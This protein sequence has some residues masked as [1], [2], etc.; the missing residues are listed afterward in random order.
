[1]ISKKWVTSE[2]VAKAP[3][4]LKTLLKITPKGVYLALGERLINHFLRPELRAGEL[5]FI[6][7]KGVRID[8]T[9]IEL[10]FVVHLR[11]GTLRLAPDSPDHAVALR[12]DSRSLFLL[13]QQRVDPDTLFFR[14]ELTIQGD[15]EAALQLKNLLDTIDIESR[16]PAGLRKIS[17]GLADATEHQAS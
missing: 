6:A 13:S 9:D 8:M 11:Q 3:M 16:L 7:G 12:G 10:C 1:M 15:T 17:H 2:L 14:R 4:G 5:D